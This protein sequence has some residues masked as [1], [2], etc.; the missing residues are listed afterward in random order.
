M[1]R[2]TYVTIAI[3]FY[4]AESTLLDAIRSVFAQTYSYWELILIDDG[5]SDR[6][7]ELAQSIDD[8]RI[9]VYSDGENRRLAARLNQITQLARYDILMRMDA[10]DLMSPRRLEKQ[11]A[12]LNRQ[13][14]IDLVATGLCSLNDNYDPVGVRLIAKEHTVTAKI[15]LSGNSGILHAS[16]MGR[17]AWFE[18]NPYKE[19]MVQSQDSNLWVRA[20]AKDDLRIAFI[21]EPLYYYREDGNITKKKLLLAYAMGRH[22]IVADAKNRFS[23]YLKTQALGQNLAKTAIVSLFSKFGVLQMLRRR[24]NVIDI[25][26]LY[27]S[28]ITDEINSIRNLLLPIADDRVEA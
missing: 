18:R 5:S 4:N 22:T 2:P 7:L 15:L 3:S 27:Q 9:R 13:T 10:D 14:D 20:Y 6:S 11:L 8:S 23:I 26:A 1:P 21:G 17:R 24:R 19:S 28:Q 16:V 12:L 25:E